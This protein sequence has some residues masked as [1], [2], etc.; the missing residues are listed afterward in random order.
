MQLGTDE[1]SDEIE[2]VVAG[3]EFVHGE[4]GVDIN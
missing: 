2:Q 1:I 4:E 3:S